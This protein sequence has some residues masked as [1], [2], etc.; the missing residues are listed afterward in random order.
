MSAPCRRAPIGVERGLNFRIQIVRTDRMLG[1]VGG[2][3]V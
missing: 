3:V 2:Q 1:T